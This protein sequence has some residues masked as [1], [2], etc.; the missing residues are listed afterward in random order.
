MHIFQFLRVRTKRLRR[1]L[2]NTLNYR[3]LFLAGFLLLLMCMHTVAMV[4]LEGLGWGDAA[5]LTITTATTVGY[6]D[7]SASTTAGRWATAILMYA[8]GI[9]VLAQLAGLVFEAAQAA[10]DQRLNG[11]I[12]LKSKQHIVIFGWRQDFLLTV[13]REIRTSILPLADADIFLVSPGLTQLP[14][15][16]RELEVNHV[17]G[18]LHEEVTLQKASIE[19]A[20]R[21]V[22]IPDTDDAEADFVSADLASRLRAKCPDTPIIISCLQPRME[23]IAAANGADDTLV[24]DNS[25]PD[26]LARAVLAL[27]SENVVEELIRQSGA[28]MI[29][30]QHPLICTVGEVLDQIA[31]RAVFIGFRR[32]DG[33]YLL[34]PPREETLEDDQLVFLIDVD[35]FGSAR[36][37]EAALSEMLEPLIDDRLIIK[38][39]EPSQVGL[40]GTNKRVT[41]QY[42]RRLERQLRGITINHLCEDCWDTNFGTESEDA[43]AELEVI[44]LLADDPKA[45]VSDAKTFLSIRM[46]RTELNYRGRIIAE[47]VLPENRPRF[48][49]SGATDVLRPVTR[50]LDIIARCVLTGAEEVLDSLYSSYGD[51]ELVAIDIE[52]ERTWGSLQQDIYDLG[53]GLAYEDARGLKVV[54]P[55]DYPLKKGVAFIL[56][57]KQHPVE[58]IKYRLESQV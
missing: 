32:L 39:T 6:G 5:W 12:Q 48:E 42:L 50:N 34:H 17:S 33:T 45:V 13:V 25:Y 23:A 15:E 58:A 37:A 8:G 20:A 18:S 43:I 41:R 3:I 52:T 47:A 36:A 49:A 30:V 53:L 44:I 14:A 24:F 10:S 31:G 16:L 9:F 35:T 4:V 56:L 19:T 57:E 2:G 1:A 51:Q 40:I 22:I 11:K 28:E 7:I 21:F 38:F 27:G 26:M 55:A 29:I 46:L 54:P